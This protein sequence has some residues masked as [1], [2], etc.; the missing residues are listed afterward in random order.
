MQISRYTD[1][2]YRV[3]MYLAIN[4][5]HRVTMVE[6]AEFYGISREHLRKVVHRLAS[7]KYIHTYTGKGGGMELSET[8][9]NINLGQVFLEFEG[10]NSL[11]DCQQTHCPLRTS[12]DL[13]RIFYKAQ[14]AFLNEI[15][16]YTL[17][18]VLHNSVMVNK[19]MNT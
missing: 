10:R 1:Y 13:N 4:D 5:Q 18:D 3:L 12:C 17:Q 19:L 11:I 9:E 8:L 2:A 7:L 6:I 16:Q 15:S 14:D